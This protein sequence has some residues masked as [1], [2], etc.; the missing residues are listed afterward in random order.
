VLSNGP[1]RAAF[2]LTYTPWDASGGGDKAEETKRFTV[3]CGTNFDAVE[4]TFDFAA[5]EA[6]VGIG[7]TEHP[8]VEGFPAAV[9]TRDPQGRWMSYWEEN[10]D[11]GL[12]TAVILA[13]DA[14]PAGFAHEAPEKSP[15]YGNHLLLVKARDN[16]PLRYF[17]GAGWNKSGQFADRAAWESYVKAFAAAVANPLTITVSARP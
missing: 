9:L 4:S 12:G 7:I 5:D 13:A 8:A 17:T 1:R 10:K 16:A 6:T 11:G 3:D 14:I 2:R 15:G